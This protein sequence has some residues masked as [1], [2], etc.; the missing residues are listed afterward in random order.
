MSKN[1]IIDSDDTG[2]VDE[3]SWKNLVCRFVG[4]QRKLAEFKEQKAPEQII[5]VEEELIQKAYNQM[6]E[7]CLKDEEYQAYWE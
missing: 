7:K 1:H 2:N 6:R 3:I 5:A 4:R